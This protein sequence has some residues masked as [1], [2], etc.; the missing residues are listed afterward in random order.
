MLTDTAD[1][2]RIRLPDT[3]T[4]RTIAPVRDD[5]LHALQ[6]QDSVIIDIADDAEGDLSLL[7]LLESARIYAGTAGKSIT[8]ARP[9]GG[10]IADLLAASG[11]RDAMSAND[12]KFWFHQ[13]DFQ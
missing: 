5:L 10:R 6:N 11:F 13:G 7:Q 3:L 8:L 1:S 4:I 2:C 9:A 12:A